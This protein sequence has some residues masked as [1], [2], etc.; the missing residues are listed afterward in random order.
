[1]E[2]RSARIFALIGAVITWFGVITQLYLIIENR[3]V[4]VAKTLLRFFGFFTVDTNILLALCLTFV[5]LKSDSRLGSF[6]RKA[7]TATAIAVYIIIVGLTYN[8]LIRPTVNS[9]GM[10]TL[11]HELLHVVTP[12]YFVIFWLTFVPIEGLKWKN[13]FLWLTYPLIYIVYGFIHGA[14]TNFYPYFF[15]NVKELGYGKALLNTGGILTVTLLLSLALIGTGKI[16]KKFD[17]GE[18]SDKS[19]SLK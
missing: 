10:Q 18:E 8:V 3:E 11:V 9:E 6:F 16:M 7:T 5:A 13:A 1:M 17:G 15:V 12:I 14:I 2:K 19:I 4:S